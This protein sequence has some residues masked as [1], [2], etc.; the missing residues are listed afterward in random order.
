MIRTLDPYKG[1]VLVLEESGNL[2]TTLTKDWIKL[3]RPKMILHIQEADPLNERYTEAKYIAKLLRTF[4]QL[5]SG[6][7]RVVIKLSSKKS[8]EHIFTC[9]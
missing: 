5:I 8:V 2:I 3:F 1:H 6:R 4:Q 7:N 9:Q